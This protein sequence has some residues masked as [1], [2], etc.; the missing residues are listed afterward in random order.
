MDTR[1]AVIAKLQQL[2]ETL[3]EKVDEFMDF[4]IEQQKRKAANTQLQ[5]TTQSID[6]ELQDEA[7]FWRQASQTSLDAIWNNTE[8][9][10]Y[11]ELLQK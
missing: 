4:L 11:A 2:P 3:L 5:E 10:I 9:E 1:E 7:E 8:D 6:Q